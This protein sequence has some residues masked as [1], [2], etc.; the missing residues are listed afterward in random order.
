MLVRVLK[1]LWDNVLIRSLLHVTII[2]LWFCV[3][4]FGIMFGWAILGMG[5]FKY[6]LL[7]TKVLAVLSLIIGIGALVGGI[8]LSSVKDFEL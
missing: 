2:I 8:I 4:F 3:C 5:L 1:S 6:A 7:R